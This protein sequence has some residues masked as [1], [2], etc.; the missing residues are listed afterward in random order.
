MIW[1]QTSFQDPCRPTIISLINFHD[2]AI[3]TI[4][5]ILTYVIISA[6]SA[7]ISP[8]SYSPSYENHEL[9]T[10]WTSLPGL[11]LLT[12]ALPSLRLL[13][14]L[15]ETIDPSLTIKITG[16][17]WYWSYDYADIENLEF[18]SFIKPS[19]EIHPGELRLLEVDN[20]MV[21]PWGIESRLLVTAADVLHSWTI[22][23][24]GVKSDAVP[25]R[26]N[27]LCITPSKPGIFYGQCS[28]ICGAN[29]SFIPIRM[30]VVEPHK[31]V[32]WASSLQK[33]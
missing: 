7:V 11:I 9:E 24:I 20:R 14:L 6:L 3:T 5:I 17:Q 4:I 13:Y 30:E 27:Q 18:D 32:K 25:G 19:L 33:Q 10:L 21:V 16:H 28:E 2:S 31:W 29:H 12:L 22:P 1:S 26:L 15:E 8:F 23:N